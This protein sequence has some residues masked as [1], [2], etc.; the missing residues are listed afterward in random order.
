MGALAARAA[1]EG[2]AGAGRAA[3][4]HGYYFKVLTGQG[5]QAPGGERS[6]IV[7]GRMT[8]G[9]GLLAWPAEYGSSGVMTFLVGPDGEIREK[10]LGP[11]TPRAAAAITT[12]DPDS[13]WSALTSSG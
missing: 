3:P 2:Y 12:F 8:G 10:D 7:Q 13:T 9:F 11:E 5:S 1:N 4:Y 6:W